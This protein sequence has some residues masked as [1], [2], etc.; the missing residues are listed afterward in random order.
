MPMNPAMMQQPQAAP[1]QAVPQQ[2]AQMPQAQPPGGGLDE[3][4]RKML[5]AAQQNLSPDEFSYLVASITPRL[6]DILT[7]MFGQEV[8]YFLTPFTGD[9]EDEAGYDNEMA[10]GQGGSFSEMPQGGS[11]IRGMFAGR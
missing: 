6:V 7:R 3:T 2:P 4:Q 11:P 9:D 1:Q 5:I 8:G 10:E